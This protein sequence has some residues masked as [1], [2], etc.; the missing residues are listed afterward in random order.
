MI[1]LVTSAVVV[2]A[3]CSSSASKSKTTADSGQTTTVKISLT[4]Q[5]CQ[6]KPATVATGDVQ[7]NVTNKDGEPDAGPVRWV[8]ADPGPRLL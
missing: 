6:A 7:F 3:G 4:P 2:A 1:A 8:R 5:G